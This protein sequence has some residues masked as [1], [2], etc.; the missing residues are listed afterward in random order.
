[1]IDSPQ[2]NLGQGAE[3]PD[4]ADARLVE[5]FYRHVKTWLAGPGA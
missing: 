2:K 4:F 3:D 1:M 5:N